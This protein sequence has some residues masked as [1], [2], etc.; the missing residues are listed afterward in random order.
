MNDIYS[1]FALPNGAMVQEY[2]VLKILGMGSFGI[3][4]RAENKY[5][6]EIVALKE[7]LP[8][9]LAC[10]LEG[11]THVTPLSSETE[12]TYYYAR[13]KFLQEAKTLREIGTPDRHPNIVRVRQFIEANDTAYMVMEF[14]KGQPFEQILEERGTVGEDELKKILPGLLD[15]LE[16]V[17]GV[18]VWHRDI[19]P[20]NILIRPDGSPVL[21]DFGAARK[22]VKLADR[23]MMAIFSPAYAAPEQIHPIGDQGP[24]TDIY[25]LAATLYRA[26]TG[27]IPS[28]STTR[29]HN[30]NYVP[31]LNAADGNYSLPFLAA[32]D[33]GLKLN[34]RD[35]PQSVSNW[36]AIF[37]GPDEADDDR[38]RIR[39][40]LKVPPTPETPPFNAQSPAK[41][42]STSRKPKPNSEP[43]SFHVSAQPK[44]M[45]IWIAAALIVLVSAL[46]L[47][48]QQ[49]Y[50]PADIEP[51]PAA[52]SVNVSEQRPDGQTTE[53]ETGDAE[54]K[55]ED[56]PASY[57]TVMNDSPDQIAK[58]TEKEPN[59][60]TRVSEDRWMR[61]KA[62][63]DEETRAG[64]KEVS[65]E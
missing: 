49:F 55:T 56:V 14:E 62:A 33:A 18:S 36:N 13:N 3:V 11:D 41:A 29:L 10:R 52:F 16:R 7:F 51:T 43:N 45:A 57:E 46:W 30:D 27:N 50:Q 22:D 24:W 44:N 54:I 64:A 9:E 4:Y 58:V 59:F 20:S 31:A 12:E 21:I 25:A 32:I 34:P 23:S 19:K 5:F 8:T 26:V 17:H 48:Y 53:I 61:K 2:Q 1:K 37:S 35:R 15:G 28:N 63:T 65:D 6:G 39:P 47:G 60:K 38:T 42:A 40:V